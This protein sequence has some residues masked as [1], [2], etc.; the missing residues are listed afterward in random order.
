MSLIG[1]QVQIKF[2]KCLEGQGR[3][4]E[5]EDIFIKVGKPI[6][7]V[8]MYMHQKDWKSALRVADLFQPSAV[9]DVQVMAS[10]G[11]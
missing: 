1:L 6:E 7:A 9:A 5:S 2:A 11:A 10:I 8:N 3:F 4:Q